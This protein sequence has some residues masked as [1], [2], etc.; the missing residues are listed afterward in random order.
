M[1]QTTAHPESSSPSVSDVDPDAEKHEAAARSPLRA[2][3][4]SVDLGGTHILEDVSLELEAGTWTSVV[5]PNGS[6]KTTLLRAL[7]GTLASSGTIEILGRS[8]ADWRPRERAKHLAFV[9]QGASVGFDLRVRDLVTLGRAPHRG[10]FGRY[11]DVDRQAVDDALQDV[12]IA[13]LADRSVRSL[14]GGER[15][16]AFLAQALAQDADLLFLDEPTAHLDVQYQYSLLQNV[17]THVEGGATVL[18]VV[19][20]LELAARFADR[21]M[22][23]HGGRVVASGSP[24]EVLT[25][26]RIASVFSMRAHVQPEGST[27]G[28]NDLQIHYLG[29]CASSRS[30]SDLHPAA[31]QPTAGDP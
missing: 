22:V 21:V 16:R 17:R 31:D 27:D 23:L 3:A 7:S 24:R 1:A 9:Q 8:L 15:Q 6:G 14:S 25:E 30:P 13:D 10:W 4:V 11:T 2:H 19:H 5:G 12:G 20:D 29:P 28:A 18:A 26:S